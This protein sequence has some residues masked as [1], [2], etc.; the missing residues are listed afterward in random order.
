VLLTAYRDAAAARRFFTWALRWLRVTPSEVVTDAAPVYLAVLDDL[1]TGAWHHLEQYA[2]NRIEADHGQLKR[3][4][5]PMRGLQT[6]RSAQ[7][8]IAGHAFVQN[9]VA[10]ATNSRPLRTRGR[11]PSRAADGRGV[12]RT[13][14]RGHP[15][16]VPQGPRSS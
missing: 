1:V 10:A 2:S 8:V 6:D 4:L 12:H 13:R 3:R 9:C 7:T 16:R 11:G 15:V 5:R 14:P